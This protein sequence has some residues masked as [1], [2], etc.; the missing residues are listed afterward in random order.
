MRLTRYTDYA[1]RVLIYL[2]ARPGQLCSIREIARAYGVSQSHLMKVVNDL[3]N[4]GYLTSARGRFGGIRLARD[5]G[6]SMSAPSCAIPRTGSIW[7][8]APTA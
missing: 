5:P 3:V 6:R 4:A 8:I 1:M 2:A 7:S